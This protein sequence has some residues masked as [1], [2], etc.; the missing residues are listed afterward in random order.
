M[1]N[2]A[3]LH[4]LLNHFPVIGT[5]IGLGLFLISLFKQ[6]EDL[7][8]GSLI[9][10]AA[11]AL[12]SIPTFTSGVGAKMMIKGQQGVSDALLDRHE[13]SAMLSFWFIEVLGGMSLIGLWE[14][15]KKSRQSSWNVAAVLLLSLL[16]VL[17]MGRTSNTGGDIRHPE[18]R[19]SQGDTV[20]EGTIGSI[21]H[22]FEPT[23][24]KFTDAMVGSK[25]WWAFMMDLHFIGLA[26]LIGTVGILDLRIMGFAKQMPVA[27]LHQFIPWAMAGLAFNVAT[28]MLAFIGM[29][30]Y[31]TYDAAF[32]LKLVALMLLGLNVAAFYLTGTFD[33]IEHLGAGEDAPAFAKFIAGSSLFLW[34]AVIILGR[35]IQVLQ[36]SIPGGS[37]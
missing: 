27:P 33:R 37:N 32:W 5:I 10:F 9:I 4:L 22:V 24:D 7:K 1:V 2:F 15:H 26:L 19:D 17:L 3:H 29:P 31:Y 12:L 11:M 28:G 35:Y 23:P 16:T 13:G 20:T 6:N 30:V 18:I 34:F 8:R 21:V 36:D 14:F 25:W